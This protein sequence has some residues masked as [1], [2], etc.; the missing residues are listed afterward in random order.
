MTPNDRVAA[1]LWLMAAA[2]FATIAIVVAEMILDI[3]RQVPAVT[4][5]PYTG[6]LYIPRSKL[7][8]G[9][10]TRRHRCG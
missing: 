8:V 5:D 3:Y 1:I 4:K 9:P 10:R 6:Q 7:I 2:V